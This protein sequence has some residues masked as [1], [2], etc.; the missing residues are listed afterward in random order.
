MMAN[1][2]LPSGPTAGEGSN[3]PVTNWVTRTDEPS[4]ADTA[5]SIASR[6]AG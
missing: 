5:S 6:S 3:R 1:F 2:S 4:N